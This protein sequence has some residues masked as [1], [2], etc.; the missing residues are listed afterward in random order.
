MKKGGMRERKKRRREGRKEGGRYKKQCNDLI[1][2]VV[3]H[4]K[5]FFQQRHLFEKI[6]ISESFRTHNG[7]EGNEF[8]V[9]L[10][11]RS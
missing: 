11:V 8:Y 6:N 9:G 1:Y 5:Q 7:D 2:H 10:E 3:F 4:I